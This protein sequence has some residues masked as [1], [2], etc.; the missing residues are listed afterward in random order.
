M[1]NEIDGIEVGEYVRT[2]E[3]YIGKLVEY[4]P[5]ALNYLKI[6]VDKEII[7]CN[8]SRDNFIYTRY[9]FQLKHSHNPID[10]IEV[11]DYVNGRLVLQVDYKNQNVCLLIPFTD[12]KANTNIMWYG[13]EDIKTIVTKE[14]FESIS[15][16]VKQEEN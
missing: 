11:G 7:H 9:G 3:G 2:E 1:E 14:Q 12:T 4:I 16:K 6:D 8:N 13:Y 15:Y 10:I 5:N